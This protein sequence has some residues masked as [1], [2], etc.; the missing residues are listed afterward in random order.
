MLSILQLKS[1][2]S[3]AWKYN[4]VIITILSELVGE[5]KNPDGQNY[6]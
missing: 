3:T 2:E 5:K 6:Y 1:Y 4:S